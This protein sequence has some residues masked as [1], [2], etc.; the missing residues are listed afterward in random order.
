M[1]DYW[2]PFDGDAQDLAGL[3]FRARAET[4][5]RGPEL[6]SRIGGDREA[7]IIAAWD[8]PLNR[9]EREVGRL[10]QFAREH[11]PPADRGVYLAL[12]ELQKAL[13]R[14]AR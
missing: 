11:G 5:D 13:I 14:R 3:V 2:K 6:V 9:L 12:E 1:S 8:G 4:V 7:E 10:I